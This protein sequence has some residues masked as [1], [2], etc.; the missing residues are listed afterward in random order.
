[1]IENALDLIVLPIHWNYQGN[2]KIIAYFNGGFIKFQLLSL[3]LGVAINTVTEEFSLFCFFGLKLNAFMLSQINQKLHFVRPTCHRHL[4]WLLLQ[5]ELRSASHYHL[6]MA[7]RFDFGIKSDLLS[8]LSLWQLRHLRLDSRLNRHL[9]Y[10]L[11][12]VFDC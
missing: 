11:C 4:Y 9:I 6:Q 7:K 3:I 5:I 8:H 12:K 2:R 1:L 10:L